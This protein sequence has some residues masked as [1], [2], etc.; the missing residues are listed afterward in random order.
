ME[1]QLS[2][3]EKIKKI[4]AEYLDKI[5]KLRLKRDKLVDDFTEDLEK[6]REE[7]LLKKIKNS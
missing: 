5:S 2:K 3:K 7:E 4:Y 6:K 1:E